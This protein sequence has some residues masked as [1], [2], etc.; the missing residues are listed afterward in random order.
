MKI[1]A[2]N[3]G[4]NL[5]ILLKLQHSACSAADGTLQEIR[6]VLNLKNS[7]PHFP[8]NCYPSVEQS[9]INYVFNTEISNENPKCFF[10]R[11]FGSFSLIQPFLIPKNFGSASECT[12]KLFDA[13]LKYIFYYYQY[14]WPYLFPYNLLSVKMNRNNL[15]VMYFTISDSLIPPFDYCEE[16]PFQRLLHL[17]SSILS[18]DSVLYIEMYGPACR[19]NKNCSFHSRQELVHSIWP[20]KLITMNCFSSYNLS[21]HF[22]IHNAV[23]KKCE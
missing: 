17:W 5:R 8:F 19:I 6:K 13:V 14:I 21:C 4:F 15:H 18:Y 7:W 20:W 9:W 11:K 1:I 3:P 12:I 16:C 23:R 10:I 2:S 22:D